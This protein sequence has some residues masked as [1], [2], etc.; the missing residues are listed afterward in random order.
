MDNQDFLTDVINGLA[1][2]PKK[3]SSKYF[4]DEVGDRLFHKIMNQPEYYLTCAEHEILENYSREF[5]AKMNTQNGI[6]IIEPGAGDGLKTK[7][8]LHELLSDDLKCIYNPIDISANVLDILVDSLQNLY[9]QLVCE[10]VTADYTH[11]ENKISDDLLPRLMLFLGSNIGNYEHGQAVSLLKGF[12]KNL[13]R[14]DFLLLGADMVKDPEIILSAYNDANGFTALF[15]LNLLTRINN[16]LGGD[17]DL[18]D[19]VHY[20]I[21]NPVLQQAESY[22]VAKRSVEVNI[23]AAGKSFRINQWE[24]IHT[25]ISRKYTVSNLETLA[26]QSGFE[27]TE[28]YFDVSRFYCCSLWKKMD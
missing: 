24:P 5:F 25:E 6:R 21:Y 14:G 11:L 16:E 17:F 19:F 9:P 10:P 13:R 3:L 15:N 4:Y 12:G 20:P 7:I 8:I 23:A 28:N 2:K 26:A 1:S 22:L 18:N 27:I